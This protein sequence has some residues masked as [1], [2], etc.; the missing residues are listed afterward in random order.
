M[1]T[2]ERNEHSAKVW[3][4]LL[5]LLHW[6]LAGSIAVAFL[7]GEEALNMHTW[8]GLAALGVVATRIVW[9]LIGPCHARF[10]DFIPTPGE[11]IHHLRQMF[12]GQPAHYT[13]HNPAAGAM[14]ILLLL[15]VLGVIASGLLGLTGAGG[16]ELAEELHEGLA[17]ALLLLIGLHVSGVIVS[18]LVERQNLP[19]GMLTGRKRVVS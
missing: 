1:N 3:D 5:R 17:W 6:T 15:M 10:G 12:A 2:T 13:G 11:V 16:G 9:G 19:L 18:S 8:A 4:P 7:T 14:V